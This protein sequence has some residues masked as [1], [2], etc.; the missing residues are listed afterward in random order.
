MLNK[1][2]ILCLIISVGAF[3]VSHLRNLR[4]SANPD[5]ESAKAQLGNIKPTKR[6]PN[7][8]RKFSRNFEVSTLVDLLNIGAS[9]E[10]NIIFS[11]KSYVPRSASLNLTTDVFGHSVNLFEVSFYHFPAD[12]FFIILRIFYFILSLTIHVLF[13]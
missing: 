2:L 6:F 11:Q 7:D 3:I 5:R 13:A 8:L 12:F 1:I 4:A 10:S 9:A